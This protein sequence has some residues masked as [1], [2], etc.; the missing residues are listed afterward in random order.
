VKQENSGYPCGFIQGSSQ[1]LL[2]FFTKERLKKLGYLKI[3]TFYGK[4]AC[5]LIL[6]IKNIYYFVKIDFRILTT[7]FTNTTLFN[8]PG[9]LKSGINVDFEFYFWI[10]TLPFLVS[11]VVWESCCFVS[12]SKPYRIHS[13][14]LKLC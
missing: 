2:L 5:Q 3:D 13:I 14:F 7:I 1:T 9:T 10:E 11:F 4:R 8:Y 12:N 6:N